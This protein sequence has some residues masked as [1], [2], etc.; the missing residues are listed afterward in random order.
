MSSGPP[1]L[2]TPP[3]EPLG[4]WVL[5]ALAGHVVAGSLLVVLPWLA[6]ADDRAPLIDPDDVMEVAMVA[7]PKSRDALP[8][9]ATRAPAPRPATPAPPP[10]P[11]APATPPPPRSSD[12]VVHDDK[13]PPPPKAVPDDN[14]RKLDALAKEL[15]MERLMAELSAPSGSV[16]R[17]A[18]SP[19]GVEGA[20]ATAMSGAPIGD[21]EYARY[22]ATLRA[23]FMEEF[24]PLPTLKGKGLSCV[25]LVK[26]DSEGRV[27]STKVSTSSGND[28]WDRAS[29]AAAEAVRALPLPPERFRERMSAGYGIRFEE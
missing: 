28:A 27:T 19:D 16:D 26:V 2:L 17:D 3:R 14:Q 8:T 12:L 4:P 23:I 11:E 21:P 18:S 25:V 20:P 15:E 13:A 6:P 24:R 5:A 1:S 7:M 22:V 10:P 29:L 9:R